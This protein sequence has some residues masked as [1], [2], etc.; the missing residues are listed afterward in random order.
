[1]VLFVTPYRGNCEKCYWCKDERGA[2]LR[3]LIHFSTYCG[4]HF[5]VKRRI[6]R[7]RQ[8]TRHE[9]RGRR[10]WESAV[11]RKKDNKGTNDTFVTWKNTIAG[12]Y[13][14]ANK[15]NTCLSSLVWR[16][17]DTGH[18]IRI[19]STETRW[20]GIKLQKETCGVQVRSS[21]SSI[22]SM[23]TT[24]HWVN[25]SYSCWRFG[26]CRSFATLSDSSVLGCLVVGGGRA[27]HKAYAH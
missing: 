26:G 15:C 19:Q 11:F 4:R 3:M 17:N 25:V 20:N 1:M 10:G 8:R 12:I 24:W 27:T 18:G 9:Q 16:I 2:A 23:Y 7:L 5:P 22:T 21:R 13:L 14:S 6:D